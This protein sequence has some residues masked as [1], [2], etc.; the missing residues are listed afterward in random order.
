[1]TLL[2]V[3]LSPSELA[4]LRT[5]LIIFKDCKY[6]E[7][8]SPRIHRKVVRK[9]LPKIKKVAIELTYTLKL[10]VMTTTKSEAKIICDQW[11]DE[12]PTSDDKV[13]N[14]QRKRKGSR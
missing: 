6:C 1:M 11:L 7:Q 14:L 9:I 2:N 4:L 13:L 5:A 12:L 3:E 8:D 10:K